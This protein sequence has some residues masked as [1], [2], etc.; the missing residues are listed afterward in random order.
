MVYFHDM[1]TCT[2]NKNNRYD[3][4]NLTVSDLQLL[5]EAISRLFNESSRTE[6]REFR[7]QVLELDRPIDNELY[8]LTT[9]LPEK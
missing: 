1:I 5:Q 4:H 3:L 2:K 6:H 8:K 7:T 9:N